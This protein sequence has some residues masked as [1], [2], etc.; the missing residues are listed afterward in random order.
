LQGNAGF[1]GSNALQQGLVANQLGGGFQG[2][3]LANQLSQPQQNYNSP[4]GASYGA[5]S[6]NNLLGTV[7]TANALGSGTGLGGALPALALSGAFNNNGPY[8]GSNGNF[9]GTYLTANALGSGGTGLSGA[10]PAL[11]LSGAFNQGPAYPGSYNPV[12]QGL[13][14]NQFGG[15]V[16]GALT[17]NALTQQSYQGS[18]NPVTQGLLANQFGG[19]VGGVL[20]ANAVSGFNNQPQQFYNGQP[21][22]FYSQFNGGFVQPTQYPQP[23]YSDLHANAGWSATP[24]WNSD[25]SANAG[26][27]ATPQWHS[28]FSTN[29]GFAATPQWSH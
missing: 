9:L 17:A 20:A 6:S 7:L 14:A 26:W 24:Q 13:L 22:Q 28:D 11:A 15:G 8:A 29:A 19:G 5:S 1:G 18:Y 10:L 21:Q 12:T 16:S 2:A 25:F 3:Y 4:Y 23:L 27:S